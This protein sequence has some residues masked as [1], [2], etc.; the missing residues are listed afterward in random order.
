VY[1][2]SVLRPASPS[3]F[4]ASSCGETVVSSWIMMEAEIYGMM[5]KAKIAMR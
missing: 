4:S 1:W 3:F 2:F 5:F